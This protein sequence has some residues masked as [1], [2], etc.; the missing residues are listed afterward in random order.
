MQSFS[1][2]AYIKLFKI[3]LQRSW[4]FRRKIPEIIKTNGETNICVLTNRGGDPYSQHGLEACTSRLA[5]QPPSHCWWGFD[6]LENTGMLGIWITAPGATQL[7]A[8]SAPDD[9]R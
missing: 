7:D 9:R 5:S 8:R 6:V 3:F 2:Q 4:E 1:A